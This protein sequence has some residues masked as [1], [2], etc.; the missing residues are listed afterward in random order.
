MSNHFDLIVI[1]SGPGGYTTAARAAAR[2]L[3]VAVIERGHPGGT[4]LNRGCIPTKALSRSAEVIRTVRYAAPFGVNIAGWTPDYPAAAARRDEVVAQL[5]DG[6]RAVL[7]GCTL[8]Q[9]E[10]RFADG[11]PY[12]L[13][14]GDATYT[15]GEVLLATGSAPASLPIPGAE[16]CIDSDTLL[17]ADTLPDSIAIIGGGVIGMEF[18]SILNA[19]GVKVTVLEYCSEIL[20]PFDAEIAKRLRMSLKRDGI[21]IVT[22]AQVTTVEG[23]PGALTV[24]ATVKGKPKSY[25]AQAVLM[26]V[27]RRPVLP[28]GFDTLGVEMAGRFPKVDARMHTN[29]PHLSVIGDANGL[30]MLAHAAETQGEL[31]LGQDIDLSVI[32]AAVFTAP[33]CAMV[34]LTQAQAPQDALIGTATFR[35]NGK[36]L[37]MGEP[38]GLVKI[39]ADRSSR[40]VLGLHICG[41]HAADLIQEGAQ[42]MTMQGTL[43]D[44]LKTVHGHPT[45]SETVTA[46]ARNVR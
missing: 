14:V 37:A 40:R 15:A 19:F 12:T 27:G 2:G 41:A 5:R 39:V 9:G 26:A 35:A 3:N 4:C 46:A 42:L 6:V 16:L 30:C 44:L 17:A 1:G 28:Q 45:L 22:S 13:L 43:D 31:W 25:A 23:N 7:G 10:A 11:D 32:P 38:D 33:E 18:A 36:A 20:P 29:V 21:E 34:G 24:Q 8:I